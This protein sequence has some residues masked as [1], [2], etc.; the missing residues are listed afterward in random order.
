MAGA[1][2]LAEF[3]V[4]VIIF[5]MAGITG[6]RRAFKDIIDMAFSAF[7]LCMFAFQLEIKEIM[8]KSG[9]FPTRRLVASRAILAKPALMLI[10][11]KMAGGAISGL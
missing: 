4:V 1:A 11:F 8:V 9:G 3:P 10:I 5:L 6:S 7:H 2:I